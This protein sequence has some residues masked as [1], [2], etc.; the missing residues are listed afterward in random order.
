MKK[1]IQK[2]I[3]LFHSWDERLWG[4]DFVGSSW[5]AA[6]TTLLA[7]LFGAVLTIVEGGFD[8]GF[9]IYIIVLAGALVVDSV[10]SAKSVKVAILR[11]LL[12]SAVVAVAFVAGILSVIVAIV[13]LLCINLLGGGV[14]SGRGKLTIDGEEVTESSNLLGFDKSYKSKTSDRKWNSSDGGRTATEE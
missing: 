4:D 11:P 2:F 5:F 9:F 13:A 8:D 10:L 12:I 1:R 14:S 6:L 7:A 3:Q